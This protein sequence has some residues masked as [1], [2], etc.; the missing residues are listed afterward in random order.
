MAVLLGVHAWGY[1]Q[2]N[3]LTGSPYSLFGLGVE[4]NSNIGKNSS[5]GNGG[6]ALRG[7]NFIN[8]LNPASFGAFNEKTFLYDIGFLVETSTISN[9]SNEERRIAGSISNLAF[10]SSLSPR[11]AFGISVLPYSD[12]GYS[13]LGIEANIEGSLDEF[14]SNIRGSGALNELKLNYGY[15]VLDNVRAGV[16]L[17]YLF[18]SITEDEDIFTRTSS[19]S[20]SERNTYNGFR[21]GLGLQYDLNEKIGFGLKVDFPTSLS[22]SRDREVLKTLDLVNAFVEEENDED[23]SNFDL[24][25]EIHQGLLYSFKNNLSLN[26]DYSLRFWDATN[27]V[28]NIGTFVDQYS[29]SLGAEYVVD[30]AGFKWWQRVH[31]RAGFEYDSGYLQINDRNID[32]YRATAGIGLPIGIRSP[33]MINISFARGNRGNTQGFLVA[34]SFN[35][36]NINITLRDLWFLRRK[37]D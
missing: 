28:D 31:F 35:T 2:T 6:Y 7:T 21:L 15:S 30:D 17:A 1:G 37:V 22:G 23:L 24:P 4:T 12:V 25:L 9:R 34:E 32:S 36:V 18:G 13:L 33:S 16:Q 29:V 27:Q 26:L 14:R 11:S 5:L 20:I 19:L 8:D 3:N 10:A